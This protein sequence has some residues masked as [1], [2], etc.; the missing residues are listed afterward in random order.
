LD[1]EP[2]TK[3]FK[4]SSKAKNLELLIKKKSN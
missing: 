1:S 2:T 3:E 4:I